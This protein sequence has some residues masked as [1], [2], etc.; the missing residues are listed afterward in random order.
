M[1]ATASTFRL[2]MVFA[3]VFVLVFA[4]SFALAFLKGICNCNVWTLVFAFALVLAF[5][6]VFVVYA[7]MKYLIMPCDIGT[8]INCY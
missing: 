8:P 3:S 1:L 5:A 6:L 4:S 2:P 7:Y